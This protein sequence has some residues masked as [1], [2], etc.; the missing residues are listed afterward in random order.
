MEE[1]KKEKEKIL[2]KHQRNCAERGIL[3]IKIEILFLFYLYSS[4][5]RGCFGSYDF[6]YI[7]CP[8][9][10]RAFI[11]ILSNSYTYI[12]VEH[13]SKKKKKT[14]SARDILGV[15]AFVQIGQCKLK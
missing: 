4:F 1:E 5:L 13:G 7:I 11:E 9:T 6:S 3:E 14:S 2:R 15:L 12:C 10:A 8:A